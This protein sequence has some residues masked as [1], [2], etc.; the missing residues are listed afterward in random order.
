[1]LKVNEGYNDPYGVDDKIK[2]W[3]RDEVV[4][5][6][7]SPKGEKF[8]NNINDEYRDLYSSGHRMSEYDTLEYLYRKYVK[9]LS[10]DNSVDDK[11]TGVK[12]TLITL[13]ERSIKE[14][15]RINNEIKSFLNN[16]RI[17]AFDK[18][19]LR[20]V[21][22]VSELIYEKLKSFGKIENLIDAELILQ[23]IKTINDVIT[24]SRWD[25]Y[26]YIK[27]KKDVSDFKS[28]NN[29]TKYSPDELKSK[30]STDLRGT[31]RKNPFV[32]RPIFKIISK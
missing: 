29:L 16:P 21:L 9:G 20:S 5:F 22:S 18:Q 1:M 27:G 6:M 30:L 28:L 2:E 3:Y 24:N 19:T 12:N 32:Y 13:F 26:D 15:Q 10:V 23:K 25:F 4:K 17:S 8:R 31:I 11:T 14:N 7:N